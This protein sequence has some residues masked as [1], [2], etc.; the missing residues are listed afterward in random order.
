MAYVVQAWEITYPDRPCDVV[1][2]QAIAL[3]RWGRNPGATVASLVIV[4]HDNG[5]REYHPG[6]VAT[7]LAESRRLEV[8]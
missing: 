8:K 1:Y 5:E 2:D 6:A 7:E 3:D 4:R